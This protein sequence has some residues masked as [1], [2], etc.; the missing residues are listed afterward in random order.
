MPTKITTWGR[1]GPVYGPQMYEE[2]TSMSVLSDERKKRRHRRE[3]EREYDKR[4]GEMYGK[5]ECLN[6]RFLYMINRI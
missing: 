2:E 3:R 4:P 5:C 1:G 6:V